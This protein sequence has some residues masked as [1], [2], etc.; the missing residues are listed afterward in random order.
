MHDVAE[1]SSEVMG[2]PPCD[3]A[4]AGM[5]S[6][7]RKEITPYSDFENMIILDPDAFKKDLQNDNV[8]NESNSQS[9]TSND[10][11]H[12]V[13]YPTNNDLSSIEAK[14]DTSRNGVGLS[15]AR[16]EES[17][18]NIGFEMDLNNRVSQCSDL[19]KDNSENAVFSNNVSSDKNITKN[20]TRND[21]SSAD[22]PV[23][24]I[25]S[26][27]SPNGER[28][29]QVLNYFRWFSVILQIILINFGETIIPSVAI[30]SLNNSNSKK[31]NWFYDK[32]TRRG[33]SFD[34]MMPH[35]CKFPLGRQNLTKEKPWKT[36][37][38]KPVDEMLEYLN[39]EESLKN[40]YHLGSI[41]TKTCYVFGNNEVYEKYN[42]GVCKL[43]KEEKQ[44][45]I[46]ES[47]TKQ[48]TEDLG[49]FAA[50]QSLVTIKPTQQFNLKQIVY[51]SITLPIFELGRLYQISSNSGF[52]AL[53]KLA[54][55]PV[56]TIRI[57]ENTKK[58][59][60]FALALAC[61]IRLKWYSK[62]LKQNDQVNSI[63][64]VWKLI[65]EPA[66]LTYFRITYALQCDISK[67]LGLKKLHLYSDPK[68]L[69][70]RL[71]CLNDCFD[72]HWQMKKLIQEAK[73]TGCSN[74]RY[75]DFDECLA[76]IENNAAD[77]GKTQSQRTEKLTV[78]FDLFWELSEVLMQKESYD[79]AFE[80]FQ[81]CLHLLENKTSD[82]IHGKPESN[83]SD[84]S[85]VEISARIA[86]KKN[87]VKHCII[88]DA[89]CSS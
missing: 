46:K 8:L 40:G 58:R 44:D 12:S 50:R 72:G 82:V 22:E 20:L 14:N 31:H 10:D 63:A 21:K 19:S 7:A 37:L 77:E 53:R 89:A 57:S 48:M 51:R 23:S 36:E 47:V 30:S 71:L 62:C 67:R 73:E 83:A 65:G 84:I 29:E 86:V 61:E 1:Y 17:L 2:K 11:T 79:E 34:G 78:K 45:S 28:R 76:N 70:A 81:T 55:S 41:L 88:L 33:I 43:I 59:L 35:A 74:R 18:K 4:L 24:G 13:G 69:N 5:G 75:Y 16:R 9:S 3:F 27:D 25:C 49:N 38:I 56:I 64:E 66:A 85:S 6:L 60:M 54:N 39:S 87:E 42:S 80:W 52:D 15:R 68:L 26:G 32:F